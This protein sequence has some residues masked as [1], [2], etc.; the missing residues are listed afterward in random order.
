MEC[1]QR[2]ASWLN[3]YINI[4]ISYI[5]NIISNKFCFVN[6]LSIF[7]QIKFIKNAPETIRGITEQNTEVGKYNRRR[8][9]KKQST[10]K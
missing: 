4:I 1:T 6:I 5:K 10:E 8:N 7:N 3:N 9:N 2:I